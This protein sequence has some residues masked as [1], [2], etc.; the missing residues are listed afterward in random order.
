MNWKNEEKTQT[1]NARC[2]ANEKQ[3][4]AEPN[5]SLNWNSSANSNF[6]LIYEHHWLGR[7]FLF[8]SFWFVLF[9]RQSLVW[10]SVCA[11]AHA[12]CNVDYNLFAHSSWSERPPRQVLVFADADDTNCARNASSLRNLA[13]II[14]VLI[15]YRIKIGAPPLSTDDGWCACAAHNFSLTIPADTFSCGLMNFKTM[16]RLIRSDS[17][18]S[19]NF[20]CRHL[21]TY[22]FYRWI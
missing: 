7:C 11:F 13:N 6:V 2:S 12:M 16:D 9:F 17:C 3:T 19:Y 21:A 4:H 5:A 14:N 20:C 22:T 18:E 1:Q 10:F 15:F 8:L